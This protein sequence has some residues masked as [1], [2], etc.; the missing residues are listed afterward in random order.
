MAAKATLIAFLLATIGAITARD[1][2]DFLHICNTRDPQYND[3]LLESVRTLQPYLKTGVP[4]YNVPSLEPL[5]LKKLTFTPTNSLR[6]QASD[7]DVFG[8]S[9][10]IPHKARADTEKLL[11]AIDIELPNIIVEGKYEMNGR[12]LL[13]PIHGSG[14][15]HGNFSNCIGAVR[16]LGEKYT[17][18]GVEKIRI[19]DFNL[20]ISVGHGTL[21]LDNLFGGEQVLGDVVNNAINNNFDLFMKELLPLV[22]KA[23]SKAFQNIADNIVQ[24]FSYE[25]LFPN[26]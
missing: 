10:Y 3:C 19:K 9:N 14:G 8:A 20:K 4:D 24:Q 1:I 21:K 2:P 6:L 7:I 15:L 23:L 16:V 13:L 26:A 22:E 12:V 5:K 11:Y 17:E 18:E 25:Q